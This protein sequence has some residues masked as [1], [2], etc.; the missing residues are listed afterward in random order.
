MLRKFAGSFVTSTFARVPQKQMLMCPVMTS[1]LFYLTPIRL[2][3]PTPH[4]NQPFGFSARSSHNESDLSITAFQRLS[5]KVRSVA[6]SPQITRRSSRCPHPAPKWA[7]RAEIERYNEQLLFTAK[8]G[9]VEDMRR[10]VE[11]QVGM[12]AADLGRL[13]RPSGNG[14]VFGQGGRPQSH[15]RVKGQRRQDGVGSGEAR[16][17]GWLDM[18]GSGGAQGRGGVAREAGTRRSRRLKE[19]MGAR[20]TDPGQ[21]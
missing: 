12:D 7:N 4:C 18:G 8:I 19:K 14:Q 15:R 11:G 2:H 5:Y 21:T 20:I 1:F 16:D 13:L 17:P 10:R 9:N 3:S 6:P